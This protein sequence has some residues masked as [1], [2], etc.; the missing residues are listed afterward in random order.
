MAYEVYASRTQS[1]PWGRRKASEFN[2]SECV[3]VVL[4][5]TAAGLAAGALMALSVGSWPR[6]IVAAGTLI[7]F[8]AAFWIA[9]RAFTETVGR[10]NWMATTFH[11]LHILAFA[12][13]PFAVMLYDPASLHF[14]LGHATLLLTTLTFLV[15]THP[16]ARTVY[17]AVREAGL[18][19]L[20]TGYW[21]VCAA[22]GA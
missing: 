10:R 7:A 16:N 19:A 13:W 11:A 20:I 18:I 21:G 9:A 17:A 22:I 12:I 15:S 8:L 6:N 3:V 14:W 1:A 5:A 4:G 2:S